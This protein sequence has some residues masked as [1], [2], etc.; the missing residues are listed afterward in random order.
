[1]AFFELQSPQRE[2]TMKYIAI[3]DAIEIILASDKKTT[4]FLSAVGWKMVDM[5]DKKGDFASVKI[6]SSCPK[7]LSK[8]TDDQI[9]SIYNVD[10]YALDTLQ[11][12]GKMTIDPEKDLYQ[13]RLLL[14]VE[15]CKPIVGSDK[16]RTMYA[17]NY[18][19]RQAK[20]C[21]Y[22]LE[23]RITKFGKDKTNYSMPIFNR[24]PDR[25]QSL[26]EDVR[27]NGKIY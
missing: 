26:L 23:S 24:I 21:G 14:S 19:I 2:T 5:L 13:T 16:L 11:D 15:H 6:Q 18:Y 7:H 25:Y 1:M 3:E 10:S 4:S 12:S 22:F 17:V 27:T 9:L 8:F 20:P